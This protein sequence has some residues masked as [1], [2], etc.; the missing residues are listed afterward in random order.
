MQRQLE[1]ATMKWLR[2]NL[3]QVFR[4]LC[5]NG[6]YVVQNRFTGD[7]YELRYL[8]T[9]KPGTRLAGAKE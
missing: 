3:T 4:S 2:K 9:F 5:K 8:G 6:P 1:P 7:V